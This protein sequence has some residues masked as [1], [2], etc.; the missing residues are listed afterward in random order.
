MKTNS[1]FKMY[2]PVLFLTFALVAPSFTADAQGRRDSDRERKHDKTEYKNEKR[3]E[4]AEYNKRTWQRSDRDDRYYRRDRDDRY[5]RNYARNE[6][7]R[8]R[9][10]HSDYYY[11][12]P[13]YGRVY[14]RFDSR[15]VVLRHDH[16]D[17][18][19]Y[20]NRFYEFRPGIGY[21]VVNFPDRMYFDRLPL[22][23]ESVYVNGSHY[24]RHGNLYFRVFR[25]GYV[26]VPSPLEITISAR[27]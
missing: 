8:G 11:S 18:Y 26:V 2:F 9:Y 25:G 5:D 7:R 23:C 17:Y 1:N 6:N 14:R 22:A 19:Y 24:Y 27:F 13:Q 20:G 21:C 4:T 10:E 15:P 12:H 16:R 3:H